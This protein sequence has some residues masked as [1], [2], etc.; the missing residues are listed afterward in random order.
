MNKAKKKKKENHYPSINELGNLGHL[1]F[2]KLLLKT[3]NSQGHQ[4]HHLFSSL[5]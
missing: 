4:M 1:N 5:S 2:Y 3:L